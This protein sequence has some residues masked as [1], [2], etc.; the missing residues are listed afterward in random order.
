MIHNQ[1]NHIFISI[2]IKHTFDA[3]KF[4][5]FNESISI[6]P[7]KLLSRNA[8]ADVISAFLVGDEIL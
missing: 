4:I 2:F 8:L 3:S 6:R 1:S 7:P 5:S